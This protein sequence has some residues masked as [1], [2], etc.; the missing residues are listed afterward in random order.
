MYNT[1]IGN[2]RRGNLD[3]HGYLVRDQNLYSN[4]H[5][6]CEINSCT[7]FYNT[8]VSEFLNTIRQ[9][10]LI[11]TT[12]ENIFTFLLSLS[13]S[14]VNSTACPYRNVFSANHFADF[15]VVSNIIVSAHRVLVELR[16]E[17]ALCALWSV[18][19]AAHKAMNLNKAGPM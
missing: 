1:L 14:A 4:K 10:Q 18:L 9:D 5:R 17:Q 8:M 11:P 13:C 2:C 12:L 16:T 3:S 6:S 7:R 15:L 19:L